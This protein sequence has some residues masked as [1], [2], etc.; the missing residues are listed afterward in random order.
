LKLCTICRSAAARSVVPSPR[1]AKDATPPGACR[2]GGQA[3]ALLAIAAAYQAL[4]PQLILDV[5]VAHHA[6]GIVQVVEEQ[7]LHGE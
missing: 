7:A 2:P 5:I 1:D 4:P 6:D 3:G